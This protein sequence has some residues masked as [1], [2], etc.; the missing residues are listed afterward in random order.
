MWHLS[1]AVGKATLAPPEMVRT[2]LTNPEAAKSLQAYTFDKD[3]LEKLRRDI[4]AN[5]DKYEEMLWKEA[6]HDPKREKE[7]KLRD[8]PGMYLESKRIKAW[9][10]DYWY[11]LLNDGRYFGDR[12]GWIDNWPMRVEYHAYRMWAEKI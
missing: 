8:D 7:A 5:P 3:E 2:Y 4:L 6:E 1:K 9:K 11:R 10:R 12:H